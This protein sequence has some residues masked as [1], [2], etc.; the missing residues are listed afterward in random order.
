MADLSPEQIAAKLK[1]QYGVSDDD[2]ERA[3]SRIRLSEFARGALDI[4]RRAIG[5]AIRKVPEYEWIEE[6]PDGDPVEAPR[7]VP[8]EQLRRTFLT[9]TDKLCE[10]LRAAGYMPPLVAWPVTFTIPWSALISDNR[11]Y[12]AAYTKTRRP[13]LLLTPAYREAKRRVAELAREAMHGAEPVAVPVALHARVWVP[14]RRAGHD[15]ANFAK[16]CHDAFEHVIYTKDEWLYDPRWTRMGVDVDRPRAELTI[17]PFD[18]RS[19]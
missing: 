1:E 9:T 10:G 8:V 15:V 7:P 6:A 2:A 19:L 17:T 11:K 16:C 4:R 5:E 13:K 14:D 18:P 12:S 3:A